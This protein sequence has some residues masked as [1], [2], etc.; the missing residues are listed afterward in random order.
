MN[1]YGFVVVA[2]SKGLFFLDV[3]RQHYL[4][5][6]TAGREARNEDYWAAGNL[7][8]AIVVIGIVPARRIVTVTANDALCVL[9]TQ[10]IDFH[11]T[12]F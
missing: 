7:D 11:R 9:G 2:G 4:L 6:V 1:K 5:T 10:K 8:A 12:K 3:A